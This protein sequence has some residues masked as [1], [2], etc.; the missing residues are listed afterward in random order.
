MWAE[1]VHQVSV[2]LKEIGVFRTN[3]TLYI[4]KH[5]KGTLRGM[6]PIKASIL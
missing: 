1:C 3:L 5:V 4:D 2:A 6:S